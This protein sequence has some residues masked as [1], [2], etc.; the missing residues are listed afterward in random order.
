MPKS[1]IASEPAAARALSLNFDP[2]RQVA[3]RIKA[4]N[5]NGHPADKIEYILKGGTWS[6]YPRDYQQWFIAES[7]RAMNESGNTLDEI[8]TPPESSPY[9]RFID[10]EKSTW[11]VQKL[12]I[13]E[14]KNETAPFRC[15]GLTIE[16]RPDHI[17]I[18][19]I[20]HLRMLGCTRVEIGIQSTDDT[21]LEKIKRGHT[22]EESAIATRLLKDAGLKV[23]YHLMPGLPGTSIES[24]LESARDVFTSPDLSPDTVKLYP[25]VVTPNT[26]ME[27]WYK[28]GLY[29]PLNTEQLIPLL[30]KIKAMIPPYVRVARVI[31]DI[32]GNEITAGN[33]VTN[34]FQEIITSMKKNGLTCRCI[35]CREIGHA[36]FKT[37]AS[38]EP[39]FFSRSYKA[40]EGEEHF[41]SFESPEQEV[42]F[43]FVRLR[44]PSPQAQ[45]LWEVLPELKNAAL[46]RELHTYGS[47]V[48]IREQLDNSSQHKGLGKR[49]LIEAE[50]LS[51]K[52][53]Y[54]K[55][56][57][58]AGIGVR[59]YYRARGYRLEG[60]YMVKDL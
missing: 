35:R 30:S 12:K 10:E 25:T 11:N 29:T 26:L 15:I 57:I 43:A 32:P 1:Y 23:D 6:A 47:Q 21:V 51:K 55:I 52:N 19:E 54:K 34:L 17:S 49:L 39:T 48:A 41:L 14:T 33:K 18:D 46:I 3:M 5:I 36:Y 4:L 50:D 27:Y 16:T 53:G 13:T 59:E 2:Y 8:P 37:P 45:E 28:K 42:I 44:F 24:D 56:A 38:F 9:S 22:R 31:R 7:L 58:I 20:A 40:S 60:T